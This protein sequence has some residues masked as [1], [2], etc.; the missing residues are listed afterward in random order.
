M[1]RIEEH[2]QIDKQV[3]SVPRKILGRYEIWKDVASLSGPPGLRFAKGYGDEALVGKW[4]GFRAS[5]LGDKW[6]VIYRTV[7]PQSLFQVAAITRTAVG[8]RNMKKAQPAKKR[9]TVSVGRAVRIARE[10]QK[11][12]QGHVSRLTGMSQST[13]SAIENDRLR[14]GGKRAKLLA[15]V[16]KCHPG[17]LLFPGWEIPPDSEE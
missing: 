4:K 7:A 17:M 12:S 2:Q 5:Q 15:H 16:L 13:I 9:A 8:D 11:V 1:W 3:A 10:L 14:V 6:R